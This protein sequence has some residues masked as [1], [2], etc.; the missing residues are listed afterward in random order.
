LRHGAQVDNVLALEVVTG[1]GRRMRCS[2]S[3]A[4]RLF[5]AVL[6]GLGQCAV[7]T[8]AV[9]RVLPAPAAVRLFDLLY[10]DLA[11][12]AADARMVVRDGRFDTVQGLVVPSP[13][14]GWA[15]LLEATSSSTRS[16]AELLAGLRDVRS[17][18]AIGTMPFAT[19]ASRLDP[20]VAAQRRSGDWARPHPWFDVWLPDGGLETFA[21]DVLSKLML[22]DTGGGPILLYPTRSQPFR[23][24]LLRHPS[25]ELMWQF[26]ILRNAVPSARTAQ[27]MVD[28]NRRLLVQARRIGG[29]LYPVGAVPVTGREWEQHYGDAW[30]E[31]V[32]AKR[33]YDP[34]GILA[35]GQ[36]VFAP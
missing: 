4:P 2:R 8:R 20:I 11:T 19:Y 16:D 33:R 9:I 24:P 18:A 29:Y 30:G 7:I 23:R 35:P 36:G 14:G 17:E 5:D 27:Q 31:L 3:S 21:A 15:Y 25:S 22:S 6:A 10:I 34:A 26:D 1:T 28:D 32:G 13:V 12:F